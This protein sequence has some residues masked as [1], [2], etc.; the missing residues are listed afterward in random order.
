MSLSQPHDTIVPNVGTDP[1]TSLSPWLCTHRCSPAPSIGDHQHPHQ[2]AP[3]ETSWG[4]SDFVDGSRPI[5][6][7]YLEMAEEEDK[8]MTERWK[9]DA[10]G[11]LVFVRLCPLVPT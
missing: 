9:A 8:K 10:D 2:S 11:I 1:G 7:K 3:K 6:S 4:E 5:F